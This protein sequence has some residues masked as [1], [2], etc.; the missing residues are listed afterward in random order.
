M[1]ETT[2]TIRIGCSSGFW[3]DSQL[4]APQLIHQG[5]IDFLIADY[6]AEITLS[7][8]ARM[9]AKAPDQGY[10]VDFVT[11]VMAPLA[12][13]IKKRGIR[14]VTNAGGMNPRACAAAVRQVAEK[15]GVEFKVAVVEGDDLLSEAEALRPG[16]TEMGS[17]KPMPDKMVS[18]N[19]YLGAKPIKAALDAGAEVVITGRCTDS[20]LALGPLMHAFGWAEDDYDKLAQGS[21]AG[22]LL[23]CGAQ[24]TGGLFTDWQSVP[25]WEV[26]G[27][28][29]AE[30][31]A[32]GVF[33]ITKPVDTGGL[34]TPA[35]VAE[36]VVYE[37]GDPGSYLLADVVCDFT[38][39]SL[40]PDGLERVRV[41]G[42]KG[43]APTGTYKVSGT[44]ADGFRCVLTVMLGGIDA[45]KK[46]YRVARA[47]IAR[48]SAMFKQLDMPPYSETSIEVIGAEDTYG[49]HARK[50][51]SRDVV[52]KVAVRHPMK[53]ALDIFSRE[54]TS[55]GTSMAPGLTGLFGGRPK[56][57]PVVRHFPFLIDKDKVP[58]SFEVDGKS[59]PVDCTPTGGGD[60]T[61][62]FSVSSKTYM[63]SGDTVEVPLIRLAHGRSGDKGNDANIG[64]IARNP[65]YL[66]LLRGALT[67]E[68]VERYF[69]HILEGGVTRFE[70]P[71]IHAL[72]FVLHDVL[73]GG[74][75]ASL[76][77]DPQGKAFAQMLLDF[78]IKVP[79]AWLEKGGPLEEG[80]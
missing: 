36:Q 40:E 66:P 77:Y 24:A 17:G 31:R 61:P 45:D 47:L 19:A 43:R 9:R 11:A 48:T 1:N 35:T 15:A 27:Y 67:A 37:I 38:H 39:V 73:G 74:G 16:V 49:D 78:P 53:D 32:D 75:V 63:P 62:A 41:S 80:R 72:N 3:G 42:A 50:P 59:E 18:L 55:A 22:H 68:A 52:L 56:V 10:A 7:I 30:C 64:I 25:D 8:M 65:A 5:N 33:S 57:T 71:G 6:L 60:A 12:G 29:I 26:I 14:V 20:A 34:V 28:P 58:V 21:L 4:A 46:A 44:Y 2:D 79:A 23:E 54:V 69:A 70:W 76:R 51:A 13:E